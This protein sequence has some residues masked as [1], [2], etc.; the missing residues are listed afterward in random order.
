MTTTCTRL[1]P[2]GYPIAALKPTAVALGV[3]A[4]SYSITGN[5]AGFD[6][7]EPLTLGTYSVSGDAAALLEAH[8]LGGAV[9]SYSITGN[10]AALLEEHVLGDA[11]GTYSVTGAAAAL[12]EAHV[13]GAAVGSYAVTGDAAGLFRGGLLGGAAGSYSVTGLAATFEAT[14][15]A[16]LGAAAGSYTVSGFAAK[17]SPSA[18]PAPDV[19]G[20]LGVG[21]QPLYVQWTRAL[22]FACDA[23]SYSLD[24]APWIFERKRAKKQKAKSRRAVRVEPPVVAPAPSPLR[25]LTLQGEGARLALVGPDFALRAHRVLQAEDGRHEIAGSRS[26]ASIKRKIS[27]VREERLVALDNDFLLAA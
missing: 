12:L 8:L 20:A 4:G 3:A 19:G 9:G 25:H 24:G 13:L 26:D 5:A 1:G 15:A 22:S 23:G 2:G 11:V 21:E 7:T 16:V 10:A 17:L 18:Q 14:G 27:N 6:V